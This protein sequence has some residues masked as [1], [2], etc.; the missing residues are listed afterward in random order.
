MYPLS[1]P[2]GLETWQLDGGWQWLQ[3][4]QKVMKVETYGGMLCHTATEVRAFMLTNGAKVESVILNNSNQAQ[5][6]Y[7]RRLGIYP[8]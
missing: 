5:A 8:N 1:A 3:W 2:I 6:A 7:Y 4:T